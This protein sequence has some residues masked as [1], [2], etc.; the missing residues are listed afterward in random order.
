MRTKAIVLAV[1]VLSL[2]ACKSTHDGEQGAETPTPLFAPVFKA[3][4]S[5]GSAGASGE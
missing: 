4:G 3:P 2:T 5:S 1:L